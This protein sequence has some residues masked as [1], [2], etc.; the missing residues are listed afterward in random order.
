MSRENIFYEV[1]NAKRY[2]LRSK[3]RKAKSSQKSVF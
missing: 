1:N 3:Q 2:Y